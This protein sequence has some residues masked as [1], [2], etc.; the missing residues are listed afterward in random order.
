MIGCPI[1]PVSQVKGNPD[2]S[3]DVFYNRLKGQSLAK[4]F[5][6]DEWAGP[7]AG[8][9]SDYFGVPYVWNASAIGIEHIEF[10]IP[11]EWFSTYMNPFWIGF[12]DASGNEVTNF[13]YENFNSDSVRGNYFVVSAPKSQFTG[14]VQLVFWVDVRKV[15]PRY[16]H[17]VRIITYTNGSN[18]ETGELY[19]VDI[20][21]NF[22]Y[23]ATSSTWNKPEAANCPFYTSKSGVLPSIPLSALPFRAYESYY[24]AFGRDIRNN[25]IS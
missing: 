19:D 4:I 3:I 24:N 22:Y 13:S 14:V 10:R 7:S 21:N 15:K 5:E 25:P 20:L 6:T 1:F 16:A 8:Y 11:T 9:Q 23:T 12:Y 17:V 2:S 18:T